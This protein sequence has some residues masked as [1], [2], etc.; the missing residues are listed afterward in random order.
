MGRFEVATGGYG[1]GQVITA[2]AQ[3]RHERDAEPPADLAVHHAGGEHRLDRLPLGM[4]AEQGMG[5][6][7]TVPFNRVGTIR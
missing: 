7:V 3:C 5:M 4:V 1:A 2:V 6:G